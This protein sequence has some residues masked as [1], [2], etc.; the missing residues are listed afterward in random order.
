MKI[1]NCAAIVVGFC[2]IDGLLAIYSTRLSVYTFVW[3]IAT[4]KHVCYWIHSTGHATVLAR[5]LR[6]DK[7]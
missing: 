3:T 4:I 2:E 1:E 7:L 5:L 6:T